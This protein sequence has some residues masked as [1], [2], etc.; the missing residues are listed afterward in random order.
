MNPV[1]GAGKWQTGDAP[2]LKS[3]GRTRSPAA[4]TVEPHKHRVL[5]DMTA[6][7][8]DAE[9]ALAEAVQ[10]LADKVTV[11][12]AQGD[13]PK[14]LEEQVLAAGIKRLVMERLHRYVEQRRDDPDEAWLKANGDLIRAAQ[15]YEKSLDRLAMTVQSHASAGLTVAQTFSLARKWADEPMGDAEQIGGGDA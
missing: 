6:R 4:L 7:F 3:G 10:T 14:W 9:P 2:A 12:D 11:R 15:S 13:V 8:A 5:D 1:P